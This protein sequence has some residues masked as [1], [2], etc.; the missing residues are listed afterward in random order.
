MTCSRVPKVVIVIVW[1]V[2]IYKL[3]YIYE[4][5][6]DHSS[7]SRHQTQASSQPTNLQ[8]PPQRPN[9]TSLPRTDNTSR[10]P[11]PPSSEAQGQPHHPHQNRQH[12]P[13]KQPA[14]QNPP[15]PLAQRQHL[16]IRQ[17]PKT[18]SRVARLPAGTGDIDGEVFFEGFA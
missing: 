1:V 9:L 16:F 11:Q 7:P 12:R 8:N 18:D 4:V 10:G 2:S 14:A 5:R 13:R 17:I 3:I 6:N 15:L